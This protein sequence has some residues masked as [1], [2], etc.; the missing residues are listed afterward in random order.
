[1]LHDNIDVLCV[2]LDLNQGQCRI[3]GQQTSQA[4]PESSC[5]STP[6]KVGMGIQVGQ[7]LVAPLRQILAVVGVPAAALDHHPHLLGHV[8]QAATAADAAG[9]QDVKLCS[10]EGRRAL[11]LHDLGSQG[12]SR[13]GEGPGSAF[14]RDT[15]REPLTAQAATADRHCLA[16]PQQRSHAAEE[17]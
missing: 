11:V 16:H 9:P 2:W 15:L 6:G 3:G 8:Q 10:P 1:M 5:L 14:P 12:V 13:G 17:G 7:H 4:R